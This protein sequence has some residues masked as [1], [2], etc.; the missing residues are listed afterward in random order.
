MPNYKAFSPSTTTTYSK[1]W[2]DNKVSST[3]GSN[4]ATGTYG[5]TFSLG[6]L[7]RR[8][9]DTDPIV[10]LN[11]QYYIYSQNGAWSGYSTPYWRLWNNWSNSS[12]WAASK[13]L[14]NGTLGSFGPGTKILTETSTTYTGTLNTE[15]TKYT[16]PN[17]MWVSGKYYDD[18]CYGWPAKTNEIGGWYDIP[19]IWVLTVEGDD[20]TFTYD[21][22]NHLPTLKVLNGTDPVVGCEVTTGSSTSYNDSWSQNKALT[23]AD[24]TVNIASGD[25][26][27]WLHAGTHTVYFKAGGKDNNLGSAYNYVGLLQN[28]STITI[29][30]NKADLTTNE[31][32]APTAKNTDFSGSAIPL[33]NAGSF[34]SWGANKDKDNLGCKFQYS[35]NGTTWSDSIPTATA[36]GDYTV[37]WKIVGNKDI[38]D[39][40]GGSF[41]SK[42]LATSTTVYIHVPNIA[43]L[44][45]ASNT[46]NAQITWP[47]GTYDNNGTWTKVFD[48]GDT[49]DF[50][51]MQTYVNS[52]VYS[53]DNQTEDYPNAYLMVGYSAFASAQTTVNLTS[54]DYHEGKSYSL[55]SGGVIH[56]YPRLKWIK[57][58]TYDGVF[59]N[60]NHKAYLRPQAA[61]TGRYWFKAAA[62]GIKIQADTAAKDEPNAP[63]GTTVKTNSSTAGTNVDIAINYKNAGIYRIGITLSEVADG[64]TFIKTGHTTDNFIRITKAPRNIQLNPASIS[65]QTMETATATVTGWDDLD[66]SAST[67]NVLSASARAS[68]SPNTV[69]KGGVVTITSAMAVGVVNINVTISE[70]DNYLPE[71]KP[72]VVTIGGAGNG[73]Y[74][75][76]GTQ[77]IITQPYVW[78]G[79]AWSE[80]FI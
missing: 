36:V 20:D 18:D 70:T 50:P 19:D 22:T 53:F 56:L 78:N 7:L 30:V 23:A 79:S 58:T 52:A 72:I 29:T 48:Y 68:V 54:L 65:M 44:Q 61:D 17:Q 37:Y 26:D 59:D 74:W 46:S 64:E 57:A 47:G 67:A 33:A 1:W 45:V 31:Y 14:K 15:G 25:T 11:W 63:T 38:N 35:L 21:G 12:D 40:S 76:D 51:N 60:Q 41:V 3:N 10:R 43:G 28:E 42:I 9:S 49:L 73:V 24:G 69:S 13:I 75:Y 77:W 62:T 66:N 55:T 32:N 8:D 80:D 27:A 71:T 5:Y 39:Y 2:S 34:K 4:S 16:F 6:L